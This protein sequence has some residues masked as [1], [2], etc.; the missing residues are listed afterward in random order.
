MNLTA[1]DVDGPGFLTAWSTGE[2]PEKSAVNYSTRGGNG[3]GFTIV[4]LSA[5]GTFELATGGPTSG[6]HVIVDVVGAFVEGGS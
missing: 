2:R 6:A 3:N 5:F 4:A 1:A